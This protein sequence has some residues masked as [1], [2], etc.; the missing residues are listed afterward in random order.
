MARGTQALQ[1]LVNRRAKVGFNCLA[2]GVQQRLGALAGARAR[3]KRA[4]NEQR[5]GLLLD[6]S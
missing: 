4:F 1:R 2:W 6:V 3:K 5:F